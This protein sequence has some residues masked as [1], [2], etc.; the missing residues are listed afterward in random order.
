MADDLA[1][2]YADKKLASLE[3]RLHETYAQASKDIQGKLDTFL[4]GSAEREKKYLDR[5]KNGTMTQEQ[6]DHWKSG[7]VFFGENWKAQQKSIAKV[8]SDTNK[9]ATQMINDEKPDVFAFAGNY[10]GYKIEHGFGVDFGFDIYDETSVKRLLRDDPQILPMPGLNV[11]KD[12]RWNMQNIRSQITQGI[13]QGESIPKIAKRLY[14][15]VPMRNEKQAT[16]HARTAMTSAHNG[17]RLQ[18]MKEAEDLGIKLNK[19]W[20]A[21]LD[22]RT[23]DAHQYLDGAKAKPDEPFR[24]GVDEIMYPGD[25]NAEPYLVYNCRCKLEEDLVD[26]PAHFA[27]RAKDENGKY[28]ITDAT[29]YAE[30]YEQKTGKRIKQPNK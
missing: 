7:Q 23:R 4:Q 27:R 11:P 5:V 21:N 29:T 20:R 8:L 28:Y 9:V 1:E 13:I 30:W 25:P 19:L 22:N 18:R 15:T 6:F 16:L 3:K 12:Q 26:Y 2:V 17:G 24:Y 10:S 14:E